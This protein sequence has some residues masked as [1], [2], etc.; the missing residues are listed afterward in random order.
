MTCS[1]EA[2]FNLAAEKVLLCDTT[3][4]AG[5]I[6]R[7]SLEDHRERKWQALG[8]GNYLFRLDK[9]RVLDATRKVQLAQDTLLTCA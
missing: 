6:I 3:S 8:L 2:L 7:S 5:E 9:H 4:C 1:V